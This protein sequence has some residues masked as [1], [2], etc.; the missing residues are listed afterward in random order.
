LVTGA[1]NRT[2]CSASDLFVV[3]TQNSWNRHPA[4]KRRWHGQIQPGRIHIG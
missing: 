1:L 3:E 2:P 4:V